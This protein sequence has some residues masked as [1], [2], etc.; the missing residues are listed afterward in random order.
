MIQKS[1]LWAKVAELWD[2]LFPE[3]NII[4]VTD[5]GLWIYTLHTEENVEFVCNATEHPKKIYDF[6]VSPYEILF[7]KK[8]SDKIAVNIC[9]CSIFACEMYRSDY[10]H[11]DLLEMVENKIEMA[12]A[13][14]CA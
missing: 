5:N 6:V 13:L 3:G 10:A 1:K 8:L 12:R 14:S 4:K 7:Y 9:E 11:E 2:L